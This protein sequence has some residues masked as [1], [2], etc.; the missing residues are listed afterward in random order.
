GVERVEV[1]YDGKTWNPAGRAI[2]LTQWSQSK[3]TVYYRSIDRLGNREAPQSMTVV[4]RTEGPK[5]DLFVEQGDLP[6][7][8][9][10]QL[11]NSKYSV[12]RSRVVEPELQ[13]G[14]PVPAERE[15]AEERSRTKTAKPFVGP[16]RPGDGQ[17]ADEPSI[18][19]GDDQ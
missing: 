6:Q 11:K 4:L 12:Q 13:E 8:P 5:V 17:S 18:D 2:D 9:L 3:R 16:L 14:P 1:S 19:Q 10:S 15:P 7:V